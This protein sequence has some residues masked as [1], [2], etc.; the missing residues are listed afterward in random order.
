MVRRRFRVTG[1]TAYL[2]N[3]GTLENA[4]A[5]SASTRSSGSNFGPTTE[6]GK[7]AGAQFFFASRHSTYLGAYP[8]FVSDIFRG[9][10]TFSE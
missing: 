5:L 3:G 2:A 6:L 1:I 10:L 9:S 7:S 4:T 8:W